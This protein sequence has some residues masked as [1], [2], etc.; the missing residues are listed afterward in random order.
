M[1]PVFC[2]SFFEKMPSLP[3]VAGAA[4]AAPLASST[5]M[6][7]TNTSSHNFLQRG[8]AD[9]AGKADSNDAENGGAL[10]LN[11]HG[12]AAKT[13]SK[14]SGGRSES[15]LDQ[16]KSFLSSFN[17]QQDKTR[18]LLTEM[19]TPVRQHGSIV[20]S[21]SS[22]KA[23]TPTTAASATTA[24]SATTRRS[25]LSSSSLKKALN[26]TTT[27][28]STA[29]TRTTHEAT[30]GAAGA[31]DL[32]N[33][34]ARRST[35][36]TTRT[37]YLRQQHRQSTSTASTSSP[38]KKA[39][40][41]NQSISDFLASDDHFEN[42]S[43]RMSPSQ[44]SWMEGLRRMREKRKNGKGRKTIR[45]ADGT[46]MQ[47][48]PTSI[49]ELCPE[50]IKKKERTRLARRLSTL[51]F[52]MKACMAALEESDGDIEKSVALLLRWYPK[53]SGSRGAVMNLV[54]IILGAEKKLK[55]LRSKLQILY[56]PT[57]GPADK[58]S[59][60]STAAHDPNDP[61]PAVRAIFDRY[62]E[63]GSGTI[64]HSEFRHMIKDLGVEMTR[65]EFQEA[66]T[67]LDCDHNGKID[68]EEFLLWWKQNA[69]NGV[70]LSADIDSLFE[71][72]LGEA[73]SMVNADKASL[74]L[75]DREN[76]QLWS[77]VADADITI[78]MP[79]HKGIAGHV[80]RTGEVLNVPDAHCDPRFNPE[81]DRKTGYV[82]K[83]LMA[84][85]ILALPS[86]ISPHGKSRP[87]SRGSDSGASSNG[88]VAATKA[89]KNEAELVVVGVVEVINSHNDRAFSDADQMKLVEL[90]ERIRHGV[91]NVSKMMSADQEAQA[92]AEEEKRQEDEAKK[93]GYGSF[94]NRRKGNG[95]YGAGRS[96][97]PLLLPMSPQRTSQKNRPRSSPTQ[98][99]RK[100][101]YGAMA[102]EQRRHTYGTSGEN[103]QHSASTNRITLGPTMRFTDASQLSQDQ[104][105][106]YMRHR[107]GQMHM[108]NQHRANPVNKIASMLATYDKVHNI[109]RKSP[110]RYAKKSIS[111]GNLAGL[112]AAR[113]DEKRRQAQRWYQGLARG[114]TGVLPG[115]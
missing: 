72:V 48:T 29:T 71:H 73:K 54:K 105:H 55:T 66:V 11:T 76:E 12:G 100:S 79:Y 99:T 89:A 87:N 50:E 30:A 18:K 104:R 15:R 49:H 93:R 1:R 34:N 80:V 102:D 101:V 97:T 86:E 96:S 43:S 24:P 82:T 64:E 56:A 17:K 21:T 8:K 70:V 65:A 3:T 98:R 47:Q 107:Q 20:G 106:S 6:G 112:H 62:D 95:A 46:L 115:L 9:L 36:G 5:P 33:A 4:G 78:R 35:F 94:H 111:Q 19:K 92:N 40:K 7:E 22:T 13:A 69:G 108:R 110:K 41:K 77:R 109:K 14:G 75:V 39:L 91:V 83:Q 68:F 113:A 42:A 37:N 25:T 32:A 31:T 16:M 114:G 52:P 45:H 27:T 44:A 51:S 74:L 61:T 10:Q 53:G 58:K 26:A 59:S 85:P 23:G 90:C 57:V 81:F 38:S 84:L 67:M 88:L 103:Y 60:A 63:D 28:S 2:L